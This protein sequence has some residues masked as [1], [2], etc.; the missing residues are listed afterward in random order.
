MAKHQSVPQHNQLKNYYFPWVFGLENIHGTWVWPGYIKLQIERKIPQ[1][2]L[3]QIGPMAINLSPG[4]DL[5]T[6]TR[7]EILDSNF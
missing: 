6:Q 7:L 5:Y 1:L 4:S 3:R 2:S